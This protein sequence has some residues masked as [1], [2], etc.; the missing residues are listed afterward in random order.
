MSTSPVESQPFSFPCEPALQTILTLFRTSCSFSEMADTNPGHGSSTYP[1]TP[2]LTALPHFYG[3]HKAASQLTAHSPSHSSGVLLDFSNNSDMAMGFAHGSHT[4]CPMHLEGDELTCPSYRFAQMPLLCTP[5][6]SPG[7]EAQP[8][9]DS[10]LPDPPA[11][12][13]T[14]SDFGHTSGPQCVSPYSAS[15]RLLYSPSMKRDLSEHS[16]FRQ[17]PG[18]YTLPVEGNED[19]PTCDE[20]YAQLIYKALMQAPGHRM[21]LRDIYEWFQRNTTKPQE[22]GT[23]GWQN[24]IRHNLSMNQV[25]AQWSLIIRWAWLISS[26]H[27]KMTRPTSRIGLARGKSRTVFGF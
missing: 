11:Y 9:A 3:S 16:F 8:V 12:T 21:I 5:F 23:N 18:C 26:R 20:P 2:V 7:L 13:E 10:N 6:L 14:Y 17:D 19:E 4:A 22:S 1:D 25:C 24:S 27:L 15:P